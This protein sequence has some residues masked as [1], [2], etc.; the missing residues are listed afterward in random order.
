[1][2]SVAY[3]IICTY[4]IRA[5]SMTPLAPVLYGASGKMTEVTAEQKI[6]VSD[7]VFCLRWQPISRGIP[8]GERLGGA[9]LTFPRGKVR[10][11]RHERIK[12]NNLLRYILYPNYKIEK[13]QLAP[14][15]FAT[16]GYIKEL[17]AEQ[18]TLSRQ[19]L[20]FCVCN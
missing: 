19:G 15:F 5:D 16:S 18:K 8:K 4:N 20:L 13:N 12:E 7:K 3:N 17:T 1:M 14:M 2:A 11:G 6:L 9:L 10:A